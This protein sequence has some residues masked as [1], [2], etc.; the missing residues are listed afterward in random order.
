MSAYL[1]CVQTVGEMKYC[2]GDSNCAAGY[3]AVNSY[4]VVQFYPFFRYYQES[5]AFASDSHLH[6]LQYSSLFYRC[7]NTSGYVD[8][9]ADDDVDGL[10][11]DGGRWAFD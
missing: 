11:D 9:D 7:S 4:A 10:G 3:Y 5:A 1:T 8:L 6:P 2:S